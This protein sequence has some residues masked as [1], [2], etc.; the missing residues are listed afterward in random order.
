MPEEC[1]SGSAILKAI[2]AGR[3]RQV[4]LLIEAGAKLSIVDECGQGALI[5]AV[6]IDNN[7]NQM[8]I[9]KL[10]LKYGAV[11]SQSD[12][13]DRNALHWACIYGKDRLV[14]YLLAHRDVDL[15]LNQADMN[16]CTALFHAAS[17]GSAATVKMI[18]DS[19]LKYSLSVDVPNFNGMTPLMQAM[20]NGHD[21]V[22]SIL[23][24]QGK[25]STTVRDRE[26][27]SAFDW[28]ETRPKK[29]VQPKQKSHQ[30]FLP[31][32]PSKVVNMITYRENHAIRQRRCG[33]SEGEDQ[34]VAS[35]GFDD[36]GFYPT[37]DNGSQA[38]SDGWLSSQDG[39]SYQSIQ[40]PS[41]EPDIGNRNDMIT[42]PSI[43]NVD[44]EKQ[45]LQYVE[46]RKLYKLLE[47]QLNDSFRSSY[48]NRPKVHTETTTLHCTKN[49]DGNMCQAECCEKSCGVAFSEE[50]I[51]RIVQAN[52]KLKKEIGKFIS[53]M[54]RSVP[55]LILHG[56]LKIIA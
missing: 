24:H 44:D 28:A 22:A 45:K 6:F 56:L 50:R 38:V 43:H 3:P 54:V 47:H 11:V 40:Y 15:D 31:N 34:L 1:G 19:L 48:Y 18:V 49:E 46:L 4:R 9:T 16:G 55:Y 5:R 21:V 42:S 29:V 35:C 32:I 36:S 30:P 7:R 2:S 41:P 12:I 14:S 52:R 23:I 13:V 37:S 51:Q 27:R 33:V 25:A 10:L 39:S 26:F 8:K 20:Y 17:S 53:S